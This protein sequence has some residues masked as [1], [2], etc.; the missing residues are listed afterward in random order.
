VLK[1]RG[2]GFEI[3]SVVLDGAKRP[4]AFRPGRLGRESFAVKGDGV[5]EVVLLAGLLSLRSK[6]GEG[7]A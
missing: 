5:I 3:V 1:R 2:G 6:R 4:P 7:A